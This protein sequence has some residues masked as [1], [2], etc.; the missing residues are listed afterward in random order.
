MPIYEFYCSDCHCVYSFLARR[1]DTTTQPA[2]PRCGR[3]R[4]EREISRFA[5]AR[6]AAATADVSA[7]DDGLP[8][9]LDDSRFEQVM[10]ELERES[11]GVDYD[12]PRQAARLMRALYERTGMPLTDSI[13]D[14]IRRMEA[15]EDPEA[16]E[17]EMGDLLG[18]P[19]AGDSGD[20]DFGGG[21]TGAGHAGT[22]HAGPGNP[23]AIDGD[24]HARHL[25]GW[26]RKLRAP[27]IDET[28]YELESDR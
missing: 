4:L 24:P 5:V 26:A 10:D 6:G 17:A 13:Q 8:P 7:P 3:P 9:G 15:G 20:G 22:G 18:E 11:A 14:A 25:R 16:I 1:V 12:D 21:D 28:L 27:R 23:S 19:F 2:C